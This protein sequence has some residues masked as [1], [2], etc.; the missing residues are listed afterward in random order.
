MST[1]RQAAAILVPTFA[2]P[3]GANWSI[4]LIRETLSIRFLRDLLGIFEVFP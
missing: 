1:N 2:F 3:S 4:A